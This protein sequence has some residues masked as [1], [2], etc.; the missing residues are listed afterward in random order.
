MG[1]DTT[2]FNA[3]VDGGQYLS[4]VEA[5]TQDGQSQGVDGTPTFFV[6]GQKIVGDVPYAQLKAAVDAAVQKA[7]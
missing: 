1:L 7:G 6:N 5:D 2:K 3:C 4:Q